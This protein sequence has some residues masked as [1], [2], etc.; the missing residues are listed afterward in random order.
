MATSRLIAWSKREFCATVFLRIL[1][2]FLGVGFAN[3]L[4]CHQLYSKLPQKCRGQSSFNA[5]FSFCFYR[6]ATGT[7]DPCLNNGTMI[8]YYA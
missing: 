5:L 1:A 7:I 8:F 4:I 3:E 2:S 6:F